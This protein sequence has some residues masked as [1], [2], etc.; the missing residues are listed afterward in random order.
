MD[1]Y[2]VFYQKY[3]EKLFSYLMRM[4]GDYFLSSD[5]L[6][7]SFTKFLE[8][9]GADNNSA[10][11]LYT[12]ARNSVLDNARNKKRMETLDEH[13]MHSREDQER[14]FMIREEYRQVMECI[15]Q[16]SNNEREIISLATDGD[17]TYRQ[18]ARIVGISENNV[19]VKIHRTRLK[20][21]EMMQTQTRSEKMKESQH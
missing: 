18:I 7:E 19:K 20:L 3:K 8:H 14:V 9:Y 16:L 12:I 11:L 6:Q 4:T 13:M 1:K 10:S 17:L 5:I 2:R 21:R 15:E